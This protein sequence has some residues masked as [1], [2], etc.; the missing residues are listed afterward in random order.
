MLRSVNINLQENIITF[1]YQGSDDIIYKTQI[2]SFQ[3]NTGLTIANPNTDIPAYALQLNQFGTDIKCGHI[4][5]NITAFLKS[6][7]M[8]NILL[9]IDFQG[10]ISVSQ[11]FAEEYIKFILSTKS[12]VISI[13]QN[14]NINNSLSRYVES[15]I[16]IQEVT[17]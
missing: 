6:I 5:E 14:T 12:K 13:N 4:V 8:D 1:R 10:V 17:Q 9:I 15:I 2:N 16:D 7:N 3:E 11:S